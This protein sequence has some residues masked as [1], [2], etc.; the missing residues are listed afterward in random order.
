[1]HLRD[2]FHPVRPA[3]P[4][5][6]VVTA[7][8]FAAIATGLAFA[9]NRSS[10]VTAVS[11][12]LLAVV[13]AAAAAGV[14]GGLFAAGLSFSG[15][16]FFFTAPRFTFRVAAVEDVVAAVVLLLVALVV[17]FLVARVLD[18]RERTGRRER[19][20]R[21]LGYLATKLLSGEQLPRVLDDF[22]QALLDPFDLLRCEVEAVLDGKELRAIAIRPSASPVAGEEPGPIEIVSIAIGDTQLGIVRA[23]RGTGANAFTTTEHALLE[24][25]AKQAALAIERARLDVRV[26]GAQLDAETNQ[27]R[28]ALFSSVT[29]DLR[30]PLASIKASVTSLLSEVAVHD[31]AQQRELLTTVLEETDRLNRVV[32]N[33]MD[34]AKI[35]A[36]ALEPARE[37]C[38]VDELVQTVVARMRPQLSGV[39]VRFAIRPDLPDVFV[40]P[41]QVDQVLTNLLE[42]A[43][44]HSP[45]GGEISISAAPFRDVIQVRVADRGSGIGVDERERVFEAF[46]R[47]DAAPE[48]PGSGLGL[49]IARAIVVGHG[50]RIWVEGAPG[51]GTVVVFELPMWKEHR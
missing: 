23:V 22:A 15:F 10:G 33:L 13:L 50:G 21:L 40:D 30:T 46:Y 47:G 34:L 1:M 12:Y 26:R 37:P 36:G 14:W 7:V 31:A 32:G 51:G 3:S 24:A 19:D 42:N 17:G 20:A 43:A 49:A 27:L 41:V 5:R 9:I 35:R 44:H 25:T 2:L 18:E 11:L 16:I 38:A 48:R 39:Q 6:I 8:G 29:H 45:P 28:A 4:A